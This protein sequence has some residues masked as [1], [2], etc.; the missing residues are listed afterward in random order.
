M[1]RIERFACVHANSLKLHM[2]TNV[3]RTSIMHSQLIA[4]NT[5]GSIKNAC[6]QLQ[7]FSQ[8]SKFDEY[9]FSVISQKQNNDRPVLM[10]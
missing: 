2:T 5:V 6:I 4:L 10:F 9:R 8:L 1:S 3:H 7:K